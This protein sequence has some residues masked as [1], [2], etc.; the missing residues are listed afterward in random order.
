MHEYIKQRSSNHWLLVLCFFY[1]TA[2]S[3]AANADKT[4]ALARLQNLVNNPQEAKKMRR[5][6][7][8]AS[9]EEQVRYNELRSVFEKE[10]NSVSSSL[11]RKVDEYTTMDS[12]S[13][14][15]TNVAYK[16]TLSDNMIGIEHQ[17]EVM[18]EL[19]KIVKSGFCTSPSA[20]WLIFG[21][22]FFY[23]YYR[24]SG[25]YYGGIII[26]AKTCGFE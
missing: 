3:T 11:P 12:A 21:Y 4:Q 19:N 17:K 10:L 23:F 16:Y 1:L 24:K 14:S 5:Q 13:L 20:A 18:L 8:S 7:L 25:S 9:G 22:E 26:D 6:V 15:G 2:L